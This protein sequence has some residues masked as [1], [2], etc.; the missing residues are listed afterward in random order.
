[1]SAMT[2][3]NADKLHC[4]ERELAL[5]HRVYARLIQQRKMHPQKA[6]LEIELMTAIAADYR[7]LVRH[8][9]PRLPLEGEK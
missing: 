4:I 9:Q 6:T 8:E 1:M 5:R 3:S 7:T 2:F